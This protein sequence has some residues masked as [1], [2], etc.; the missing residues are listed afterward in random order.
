MSE[1][2]TEVSVEAA[3][4]APE[5]SAEPEMPE[6]F[7]I[8]SDEPAPP[9]P[10][11]AGPP[12]EAQTEERR[13]KAFLEKVRIDKERRAQEIEFKRREQELSARETEYSQA[14]EQLRMLQ[15][16]PTSFLS[17]QG[18][19]P[20]EF[21]RRLAEQALTPGGKHSMSHEDRL[22]Q[23]QMQV[24]KLEAELTQ[25]DEKA[26]EAQEAKAQQAIVG[27]FISDVDKFGVSNGEKYPLIR[28]QMTPSDVAEGMSVYY[29]ETGEE[30]SI[31]EAFDRIEAGLREHEEKF[32][33]NPSVVEKFQRYHPQ[34]AQRSVK[35]PQA[36]LS[37][38]WATQPTRKDPSDMSFEEIR[39][40]YKGKLFT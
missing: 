6:S 38:K 26:K 31:E 35:G 3:P 13:S 1:E 14:A 5:V 19:D 11:E 34:A 4:P 37:S 9:I 22:S 18:I 23:T 8:F 40:M 15:E 17:S 20:L 16:D 25:R 7:N 10:S 24:A 36:T 12:A 33:S 29:Q 39:E 28:E 27:R 32:Y 2:A 30:L 21:Q